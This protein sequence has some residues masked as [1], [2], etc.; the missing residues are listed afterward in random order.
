MV[1]RKTLFSVLGGAVP[2]V[3]T[4]VALLHGSG[5]RAADATGDQQEVA[6]RCAV[7]LSIALT[8]GSPST[9]L[10]A[11]A[12]PQSQTD[13][14]LGSDAFAERYARFINSEFNG[15]PSDDA[16]SD[17]VYY[18]A[19]YV[20]TNDKP[21]SDLFLGGYAVDATDNAM[22]VTEDPDGLG[23]FRSSTWRKRYAGNEPGGLMISAGFRI[24]SNT[25]GLE[26]T[27]SVGQPGD[28]R[29]AN[30]RMNQP[31]KS[32]H[33]DSWYALDTVAK[34]LPVR[35]GTGDTVTFTDTTAGAQRL[36]GKTLR[37]D[38]DLVST[39]VDSDAWR[40]NQCREVFKFL[41]GHPENQGV[42]LQ[43]VQ[44]LSDAMK[45]VGAATPDAN[46][47]S[48]ELA[49]VSLEAAQAIS[50]R[51]M[52]SS[53]TRLG[54]LGDAYTSATAAL[55]KAPSKPVTLD[56]VSSA[57]G[58]GATTDVSSFGAMLGGA[59]IMIRAAGTNVVN[60]TDFGLASWDFH[61]L[62]GGLS[63]NGTYSRKKLLSATGGGMS[64]IAAIKDLP[65]SH[66]RAR[67]PQR[68]RLHLR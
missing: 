38:K 18:L 36:L 52:I 29:T 53:P 35:K 2:V 3:T 12:T 19:K 16:T 22:E 67:G 26:L 13:A 11:S 43:R 8:G 46:G 42:S 6:E 49:A 1:S 15:G 21:W 20:I 48:R 10:M 54:A 9:A 14:L 37:D 50:K 65:R 7:R 25:T 62:S 57:Y 24:L 64:R 23:Y 32:C 27:P 51:Q 34:L 55:R 41:Y 63:A 66:A 47:P 31:C 5:A 33:F 58:L 39:L 44:N 40:F 61:Q 60:I 28:D 30:G 59:E 68:R 4:G 45:T 17:P 56:E